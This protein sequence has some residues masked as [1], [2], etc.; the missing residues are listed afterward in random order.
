MATGDDRA[1][2]QFHHF[3]DF[4]TGLLAVG[5]FLTGWLPLVWAAMG[6]AAALVAAPGL[7]GIGRVSRQGGAMGLPP[8]GAYRFGQATHVALFA[9]GVALLGFGHPIGWLPVLAAAAVATLEGTTAFSATLVTYSW[10]KALL[11][12]TPA[13]DAIPPE[14]QKALG[15]PKC[16]VCRTL[17]AA[18]YDRCRWCSQNSIRWCCGLQ[19]FMLLMLL[20]VIAFLLNTTLVPWVAKLLVTLSI[21]AVV[22]LGLSIKWQ[23]QDLIRALDES[24]EKQARE[25]ARC[26]FLRRLALVDS[27]EAVARTTVAYVQ[28]MVGARRISV[29]VVEGQ[30]LRIAFSVG[31]PREVVEQV[32]VPVSERI[33]GMVFSSG[34]AVVFH[35]VESERPALAL[36]LRGAG[37]SIS[38]P[39]V[40]APMRAGGVK[41]GCINATDMPQREFTDLDIAEME[42]TAEA[43]AIS[44]AAQMA[45]AEVERANYDTIRVLAQVVE[46]KDPYTH[47]HSL[48]VQAWSVRVGEELGL[49]RDRLRMLSYAAELHDIGKIAVPDEILKGARPLTDDEWALM[50]RHPPRAAQMI[51][52]IGFLEPAIPA[53]LYHHERLDGRGYPEGLSGDAIPLEARIMGIVDSYDAMTSA[54][55][56][57]PAK[58]HE[59]AARELQRCAGTQFDARCVKAFLRVLGEGGDMP[60]G[61]AAAAEEAPVALL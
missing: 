36:G 25:A 2:I 51:E 57:R 16:I 13:A 26:E 53:I 12:R 44:I 23:M 61:A 4:L 22:A 37:A 59:E 54:R 18:A 48:R 43:A 35:D 6:L 31:I 41:V 47:G 52:H 9:S 14:A 40:A 55:A 20:L 11:G 27:M 29:M 34:R 5:A 58:S 7:A 49:D 50:R 19:T 17:G 21:V 3:L 32:A 33:C 8:R 45:R 15:N 42:F 30:V 56:Y 39:L 10:L 60:V 28:D 24:A 46:A 38:M 1:N